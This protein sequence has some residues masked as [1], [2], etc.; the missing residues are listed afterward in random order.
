MART[1]LRMMPTFPSPPLKFRTAG[2]PQSGFKASLSGRAFPDGS[3]LKPAPGIHPSPFGLHRPF[4]RF[5]NGHADPARCPDPAVFPRAAVREAQPPYPRG[6]W[7]RSELCCL[8]PSSRSTTPSASLAGTRRLHG[9]AAYTPRLRCAG[10]PRRPTRPSLLSLPRC[11]CVPSTLRR[12]VRGPLPLCRDRDARLPR[13]ITESPPTMARL[14]QQCPTGFE[15][16]ALHRSRHAAA[17]MFAQPSGL[18]TT[19]GSPMAC[20]APA[21][22]RVTP[23]FDGVR[24]RAPL[25]VRLKGRTGNLPSSGLAPDQ[26]RQVVR[27]HDKTFK[28]GIRPDRRL[29]ARRP[30]VTR[31]P[32]TRCHRLPRKLWPNR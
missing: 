15:L 6:P 17:R 5:R 1:G 28:G 4:A 32:V 18:A 8:G 11:P 31:R 3:G 21:E 20:I 30:S 7:L 29:P 26:S 12:W 27:L 13:L 10:A 14:C 25:G 23:A 22:D 16:S 9:S 24:R 2:F 19:R